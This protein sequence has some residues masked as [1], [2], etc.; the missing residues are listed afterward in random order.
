MAALNSQ[1][2]FGADEIVDRLHDAEC[3]SFVLVVVQVDLMINSG[4]AQ[5]AHFMVHVLYKIQG[6]RG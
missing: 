6:Y 1:R 4:L 5:D 2:R 3:S